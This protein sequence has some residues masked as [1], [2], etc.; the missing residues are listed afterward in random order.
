MQ[1]FPA[2]KGGVLHFRCATCGSQEDKPHFHWPGTKTVL[3]K[4]H[5]APNKALVAGNIILNVKNVIGLIGPHGFIARKAG[6]G[7]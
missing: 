1:E 7:N 2:C 5:M 4:V 3:Q 6:L